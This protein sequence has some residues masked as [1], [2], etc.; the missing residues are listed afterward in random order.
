[1]KQRGDKKKTYTLLYRQQ[2]FEPQEKRQTHARKE[3]ISPKENSKNTEGIRKRERTTTHK[4]AFLHGKTRVP[5][6]WNGRTTA[7]V[8]PYFHG[9]TPKGKRKRKIK[10]TTFST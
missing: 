10:I 9:E 6:R 7:E 2:K 3:A 8:R 4:L 1:M 5:P